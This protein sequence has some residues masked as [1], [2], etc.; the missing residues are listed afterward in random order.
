MVHI[1]ARQGSQAYKNFC[2]ER[3]AKCKQQKR[4]LKRKR[5]TQDTTWNA[6]NLQQ[7]LLISK[8]LNAKL[9]R[10]QL[11]DVVDNDYT[12]ATAKE[13][14]GFYRLQ[15]LTVQKHSTLNEYEVDSGYN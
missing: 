1:G 9:E 10:E 5:A 13:A 12:I 4:T 2:T 3:I 15:K 14:L 8:R 7:D 6:Y 11:G